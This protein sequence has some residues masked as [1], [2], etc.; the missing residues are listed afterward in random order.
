[1]ALSFPVREGGK[2]FFP[3]V[4]IHDGKVHPTERFD[5]TLYAQWDGPT[6]GT[7]QAIYALVAMAEVTA[8]RGGSGQ[9]GESTGYH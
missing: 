6:G 3:T 8:K 9:H 4:H 2:L 5:H 7:L 1:M